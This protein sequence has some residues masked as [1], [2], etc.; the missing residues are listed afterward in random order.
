M[1][2]KSILGRGKNTPVGQSTDHA[3][4]SVLSGAIRS[5][6]SKHFAFVDLQGELIHRSQSTVAFGE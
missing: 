2:N 1:L 3:D 4:R 6:K 5:E